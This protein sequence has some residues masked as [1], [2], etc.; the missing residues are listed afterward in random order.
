MRAAVSEQVPLASVG[1][2][3]ASLFA[4]ALL[5]IVTAAPLLCR[6]ESSVQTGAG[7]LTATAHVD[8]QITIPKFIFLRVGTG[9]GT[10]AGGWAANGNINLITWAPASGTVGN[11]VALAGTGGDLG[12]GVETAVVVANH[13]NVTL[14]ST[15]L[16]ALGDGAG[17][18][19]SYAQI[20]TVA[21]K[22]TTAQVLNVPTLADGATR[23]IT[24]PAAAAKVV[25]RDAKW[26]YTYRNQTSPPPG[27][28]G[29][30]NT[31]NGRVTYTA[32]IP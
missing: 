32:S 21:S 23:S 14:S 5:T 24:I 25:Q 11:G 22:L 4:T 6:A 31:N 2:L 10:V 17:D 16:G 9:S 8:L 3:R 30:V 27:T 28:Y 20:R 1:M 29:G 12:G 19:I 26:T 13:G 15:T 18:T 7:A